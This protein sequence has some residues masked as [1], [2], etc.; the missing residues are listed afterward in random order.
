MAKTYSAIETSVKPVR[1][2]DSTLIAIG[3]IVRACAEIE[4]LVDLFIAKL[5]ETSEAKVWILLGRTA[6]T[7][8]LEIAEQLASTRPD[9]AL[10]VHKAAFDHHYYALI[11]CR[12]AVAH[13]TL[14]GEDSG[15]ML[16]FLSASNLKPV[17]GRIAR[18]VWG[19][20]PEALTESADYA[21]SLIPH[22]ENLLD[23]K[24][25]R[26]ARLPQ[27]LSPHRKAQGKGRAKP[28]RPPQS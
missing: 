24:G 11:E 3:R 15:G 22:L 17:G 25:L 6:V 26:E 9:A 20:T 19:Y 23:V 18:T 27:L 16:H 4:D 1:L 28:Q 5:A 2:S 14:L 10:E 8:K 12:N 13:G 7:R 21:E